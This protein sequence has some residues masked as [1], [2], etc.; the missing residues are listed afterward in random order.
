MAQLEQYT[1]STFLSKLWKWALKTE[2]QQ[3]ILV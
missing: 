3:L 1:C 2:V